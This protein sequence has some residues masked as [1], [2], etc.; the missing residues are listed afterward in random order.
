[1]TTQTTDA[2]TGTL[3][4]QLPDETLVGW[5]KDMILIREFELRTMAAYQQA[6]IGG[7]CHVYIGQ[8]SVVVGTFAALEH[9]DPVVTAYRDHGHALARGMHPNACMGEMYGK[10]PGC[11][12][13]KGGSMHMFD[14]PNNLFG[15]HGIVGAQTPLGLGLAFASRYEHEV[16]GEAVNSRADAPAKRVSLAFLGDGAMNQGAFHEALNLSNLD[17]QL[18]SP[19]IF[20]VENNKYSMGTAIDRGTT[21]AHDMKVKADAYGIDYLETDAADITRLYDDF[22]PFVDDCR[23]H[24]KP[25]FV[26]LHCYRYQ[27]HSMSDPG[28]YREKSEI[29]EYQ[30]HKDCI[31]TLIHHLVK[32]RNA[33]TDDDVKA[34]AKEAK[35]ASK[36]AQKFAE[37]APEPSVD[38]ELYSDVYANIQPNLSPMDRYHHGEKNHLL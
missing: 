16:V 7:F 37:E 3:S 1:M 15:G 10:L 36:T 34:M 24:Q 25:G 28:N 30:D 5:L 9:S 29:K 22:K 21:M 33:I 26:N 18:R 12:K 32:D 35:D 13:G 2:A 14:K 20:I 17:G 38:G 6:K 8:E 4:A 11:A 19:V 27:G 31:S 23:E